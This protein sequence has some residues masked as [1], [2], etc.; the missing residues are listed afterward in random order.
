MAKV[1]RIIKHVSVE[2][3]RGTRR[4]R[5]NREHS[6]RA[7]EFCL[8]IRDDG[9][10]FSRNYC[11]QC[12]EAILK[13]C[14]NDLRNIGAQLYPDRF[15]QIATNGSQRGPGNG[16]CIDKQQTTFNS[17]LAAHLVQYQ[18]ATEQ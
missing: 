9:T 12:A 5:R 17:K 16:N 10:P 11:V 14:G 1:R 2:V 4:C 18:P 15:P 8:S 3:A 6:I 7:G 13:Q